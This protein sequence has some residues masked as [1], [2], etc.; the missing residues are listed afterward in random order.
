MQSAALA[1]KKKEYFLVINHI[2]SSRNNGPA[3]EVDQ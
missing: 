1:M 3:S 2:S